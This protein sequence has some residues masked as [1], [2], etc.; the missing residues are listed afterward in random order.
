[1]DNWVPAV[2][3]FVWFDYIDK[4]IPIRGQV[5][6]VVQYG[7]HKKD[8]AEIFVGKHGLNKVAVAL[9]NIYPSR[10][11]YDEAKKAE[12]EKRQAEFWKQTST[13]EGLLTFLDCREMIVR[14]DSSDDAWAVI[15]RRL[16]ESRYF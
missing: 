14:G 3:D 5:K 11:A 7:N 2:G 15:Q 4:K 12:S 16:N 9:E 13:L 6:R 8:H 10:Q 1:M